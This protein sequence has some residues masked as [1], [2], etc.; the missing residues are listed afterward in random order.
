MSW[1][2]CVALCVFAMLLSK[3]GRHVLQ[4]GYKV[5]S[6]GS[7]PRSGGATHEVTP[8]PHTQH[9]QAKPLLHPSHAKTKPTPTSLSVLKLPVL[10]LIFSLFSSRCP[11][12]LNAAGFMSCCGHMAVWL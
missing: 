12:H 2:V 11:L 6:Y 5:S 8:Q 9:T 10:L 7:T 3:G 1:L 4:G